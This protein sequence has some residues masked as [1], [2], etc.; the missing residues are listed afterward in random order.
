MRFSIAVRVLIPQSA[1]VAHQPNIV[2][3]AG[4]GPQVAGVIG[5][6]RSVLAGELIG[7]GVAKKLCSFQRHLHNV[8]VAQRLCCPK[9]VRVY[10]EDIQMRSQSPNR[11]FVGL[12]IS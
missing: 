9:R 10:V 7:H 3:Y 8:F 12:S 6:R 5:V 1:E 2:V 11:I 4:A